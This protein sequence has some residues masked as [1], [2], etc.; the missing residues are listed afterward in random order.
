MNNPEQNNDKNYHKT[1][2]EVPNYGEKSQPSPKIGQPPFRLA[3]DEVALPAAVVRSSALANNLNWM[4]TFADRHDVKLCPHG[5]TTMTPAFF[6]QQLQHGAWGITVATVAQAQVAALAGAKNIIMANQL[7][8]QTNMLLV[9]DLIQTHDVNFYCCV[10][11]KLNVSALEQTFSAQDLSLNVMIE[12]GIPGGRCGCR[13]ETEVLELAA[14]IDQHPHLK[15]TGIEVYEGVIHGE[16]AEEQIRQFLGS[17]LEL[18]SDLLREGLITDKPIISGAGSAWY[19]VVAECFAHNATC[20]AVIRPGCYAIHDTGIYLDAQSKVMDRANQ[21]SGLACDIGGDLESA[22]E[23][24]AHIISRP[25]PTKL[26]AG[27]GK[28]DVAFDAGLP[29]PE[30]AYRNGQSLN[31]EHAVTTAVMDQHAFIEVT[32]ECELQVG[33]IVVFSTSHPCL[34]FDKWRSIAVSDDNDQVTHWVKT[35][36]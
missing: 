5:K 2:I 10:D 8:G 21:N 25:E 34:T 15:L 36:F 31:L 7:V 20:C 24:W 1:T 9:A 33:D 27:F 29:I 32:A 19:D 12:F 30:R 13:S 23:L 28:R 26:V 6:Q 18:A 11:S 22:L 35:H 16:N 3:Y 14:F 17:T 4:Q